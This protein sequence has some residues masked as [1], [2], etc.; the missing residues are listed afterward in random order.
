MIRRPL[1]KTGLSVT[2]IGLGTVKLGRTKKL[3]YTQPFALPTEDE[4]GRVLRGALDAGMNLIDTAPA[5]GLA[6]ARVGRHLADRRDEF[7]LSTKAGEYFDESSGTSRFDFTGTGLTA[8]VERSLR[9]LRTDRVD[10]LMLHSDGD[11]LAAMNDDAV[12][13][14][15]KLK[16]QGKALSVGL[17]G[18]TVDGAM[19]AL[20]WA[21]VLMVVLHADDVSHRPV[22]AAAAERGVGV[23][24][25]KGLAS[26]RHDAAEAVAF[27]MDEPGVDTAVVGTSRLEHLLANA[28]A[29]ERRLHASTR[30]DAD[31]ARG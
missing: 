8:S 11:D 24:V 28:D 15:L 23:M 5:Y 13:A 18:K 9:E 20:A 19:A 31:H 3:R 17:S 30:S 1:G 27:L 25:K 29:A 16:E 7:V 2:P 4:A 12:A 21:D 14:L 22:L 10:V 26:G 6:E